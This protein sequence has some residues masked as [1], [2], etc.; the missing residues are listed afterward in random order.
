MATSRSST[1]PGTSSIGRVEQDLPCRL[2]KKGLDQIDS[3]LA[4]VAS[5]D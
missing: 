1:D 3:S 2:A 4:A 5:S